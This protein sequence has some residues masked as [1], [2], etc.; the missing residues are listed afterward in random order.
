MTFA[1]GSHGQVRSVHDADP[2]PHRPVDSPPAMRAAHARS[3]PPL[4]APSRAP[5]PLMLIAY[6]R[7]VL[8]AFRDATGPLRQRVQAV[9]GAQFRHQGRVHLQQRRDDSG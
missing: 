6:R 3:S 9:R 2:P 7:L 1:T 8:G 5:S 4:P